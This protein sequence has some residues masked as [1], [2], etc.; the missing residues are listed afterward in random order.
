MIKRRETTRA[1]S[2]FQTDRR[3]MDRLKVPRKAIL[4][5]RSIGPIKNRKTNWDTR[6]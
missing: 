2:S 5:S 1:N 6:I 4:L 3:L